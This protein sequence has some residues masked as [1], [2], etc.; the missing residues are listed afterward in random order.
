[1]TLTVRLPLRVEQDLARYCVERKVSKS[2][3]VKQALDGLLRNDISRAKPSAYELGIDLFGASPRNDEEAVD[4]ALNSK[5]LLR[6]HFRN[7]KG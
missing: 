6:E 2:A 7:R 3:A 1:M 5:R 4:I